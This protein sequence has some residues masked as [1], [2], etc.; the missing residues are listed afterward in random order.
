MYIKKNAVNLCS[1]QRGTIMF[2]KG[3]YIV[4]RNTGVCRVDEIS[5]PKDFPAGA[6][7]VLYYHL[8]PVHGSGIIYIPVNSP[9]FM[10]PILT[11]EQAQELIISIPSIQENPNYSKDQKALNEQYRTLMQMHDCTALVQLIK[12]IYKKNCVLNEKGKSAGKTDL[13][14][15]KQAE[16]LLH[17]ELAVALDIP[18]EEV[19]NYIEQQL[20][21]AVM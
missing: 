2:Q 5:I 21:Q 6:E 4:Y 14:Y 20:K 7:D 13:Q 16:E 19:P 11:K 3:D 15:M 1:F 12:D 10:R 8:A 17:E 9:V 18:F